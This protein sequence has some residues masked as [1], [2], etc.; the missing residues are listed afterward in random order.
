MKHVTAAMVCIV[1]LYAIDALF[2]GGWYT[3]VAGQAI[4][5]AVALNW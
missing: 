5:K 4:D 1:A 2:F 3:G